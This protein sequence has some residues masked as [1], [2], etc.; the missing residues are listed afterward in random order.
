MPQTMIEDGRRFYAEQA[1]MAAHQAF[2]R[3][4]RDVPMPASDIL[5]WAFSAFLVG[6][7]QRSLELLTRA[8]RGFLEAGDAASAARAAFWLAFAHEAHGDPARA[9]AW[10]RRLA[11]IVEDAGLDPERALV[12]SG[13]GH[14]ALSSSEPAQIERA[15]ELSRRAI[16]IARSA[17][18]TDTAVLSGLSAGW[19]LLRLGRRTAGLAELDEAMAM[20]NCGDVPT[21]LVNGVAY[22]SVISASLRTL[23]VARA[24]EWTMAASEWCAGHPE[25]VPFRGECLVHRSVVK[26]LDGDWAGALT[27]AVRAGERVRAV[28]VGPAS[29]QKGELHRLAGR[30]SAA[31]EAYRLAN[32]AGRR[33]EPGLM[34]L[35]LAQ[36]RTDAAVLSA[37]R[38]QRETAGD[39]ERLE[40]LPAYVEVMAAASAAEEARSGAEELVSLVQASP[41]AVLSARAL[42]AVGIARFAAGDVVD[43]AA[44]LRDASIR[45][46]EL[47]LPY[48]EARSRAELGRCYAALGDD[49]A[50]S[51]EFE[52]AR[53]AFERLGAA[54]DLAA[55][56]GIAPSPSGPLTAREVDVVRLVAKGL[57]NRGVA[58]ELVLSEKTIARHLANVYR[59]LGIAS[60]AA[61]TAYAYDHG[62]I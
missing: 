53:A 20:V 13:L 3:A 15:L 37:R 9:E 7:E 47:G 46:H 24:R 42:T 41:S 27:E 25:L 44:S 19:A 40:F 38:L 36:G 55:L 17:G 56:P 52:A 18:D 2:E 29:Y 28:D 10:G 1:W 23:D 34:L 61:A 62:L 22:C 21:P 35:R 8:F 32:S 58:E 5:V 16:E 43:A 14:V 59:R 54:P 60:R 11:T 26:M 33:P 49:E 48:S 30:F 57:T 4:D 39:A 6:H 45:W 51:L 50:A 12:Y 31:E